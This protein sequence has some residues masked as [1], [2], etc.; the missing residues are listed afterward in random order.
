M[1]GWCPLRVL[2]NCTRH[3]K[4]AVS[5]QNWWNKQPVMWNESTFSLLREKLLEFPDTTQGNSLISFQT[6]F[7]EKSMEVYNL[8][9][10]VRVFSYVLCNKHRTCH[11]SSERITSPLSPRTPRHDVLSAWSV[12]QR[13]RTASWRLEHIDPMY[14]KPLTY[15]REHRSTLS[16]TLK[17]SINSSFLDINKITLMQ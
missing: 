5:Q 8:F 2:K 11:K 15:T 14:I 17:C 16:Q 9:P 3:L 7:S 4:R 10:K 12:V 1:V 13:I 6:L